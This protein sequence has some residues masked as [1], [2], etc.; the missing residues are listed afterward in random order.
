MDEQRKKLVYARLLASGGEDARNA[1]VLEA[2]DWLAEIHPK[3]ALAWIEAESWRKPPGQVAEALAE[4]IGV[5][6]SKGLVA[7]W[8][9]R[10]WRRI[11]RLIDQ[12]LD[13][14]KAAG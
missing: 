5:P 4:V 7:Q 1:V 9:F 13:R 12:V 8:K 3:Q 11:W 6:V 10:A 14:G 2:L